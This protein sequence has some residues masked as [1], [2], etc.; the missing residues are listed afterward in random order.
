MEVQ[1][2]PG[3]EGML[4]VVQCY[5]FINAIASN[6]VENG[7]LAYDDVIMLRDCYKRVA[8]QVLSKL[9]S[10]SDRNLVRNLR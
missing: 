9:S 8:N 7:M 6:S 1:K 2:L 4:K 10:R 5:N 3:L